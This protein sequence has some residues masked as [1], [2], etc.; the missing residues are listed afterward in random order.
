M[1]RSLVALVLLACSDA[2]SNPAGTSGPDASVDAGH[3]LCVAGD[4][5]DGAY[6]RVDYALHILRT[7]P[8]MSFQAPEGAVSL[9]DYFEPCAP[10]ARLLVARVGAPWCGSCR[11]HLGHTAEVK[12]LDIG[13]R[14]EWLDLLVSNSDDD[15]PA[16]QDVAGYRD[17]IDAPERVALDPTFQ[18]GPVDAV[19]SP[20]PLIVLIDTRTMT[21]RNFLHDPDPQTLVLRIRQELATLDG[22]AQPPSP[23]PELFDGVFSRNQWDL[24]HAMTLPGAPPPDPTN[25]KADDVAA[26][27][28]GKQLF[29][30]SGLSPTGTVSCA[31]CHPPAS[32]YQDGLAQSRG[33]ALVD[34][35]APALAL[36]AHNRWQFWDGRADTLWMQALGPFENEK[37]FDSTRLFVVHRV[38]TQYKSAYEAIFGPL[39]PLADTARFPPAG[40][41]GD[42]TWQGMSP[43]DQK[44]ATDVY[45]NVG[46]AIAAF[47]RTLRV[48]PNRLDAYVGG[49]LSA[50]SAAEKKG[51]RTFFITGCAQCHWGPRLT[52]DAFHPDRYPTGRQDG[53]A[54]RGRADGV[55]QL[56]AS[57][58]AQPHPT[59]KPAPAQIGAF[60]TPALRGVAAS[61]P[62]GHGGTL[63]GLHDVTTL[64]G[65]AG[66]PLSDAR[67]V[68]TTE[69][70]LPAFAQ[71]HAGDLVPFLQVLTADVAP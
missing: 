51:L 3:D 7:L 28:L 33:T 6:P 43:A 42:A 29:S 54:D 26:S 24:L 69:P 20:L 61:A 56:L 12:A 34:R 65:T 30:D 52:D 57:E 66:L 14:L 2:G 27:A 22:T 45:V 11:W 32:G 16:L 58:F 13:A 15:A 8:D 19:R 41:P 35:N 17:L 21:V 67:A 25:A 40:K 53:Q 44:A 36:A 71:A 62:F 5:V 38:Y 46:K 50:L 23:P 10:R 55:A 48:K 60:K 37:E 49:D 59:L 4:S 1:R 68:G 63:A 64:Y 9:H 70:W 47:E 31:T 18:L 39:P